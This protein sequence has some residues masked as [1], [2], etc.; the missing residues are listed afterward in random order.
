MRKG[1]SFY[2]VKVHPQGV[3]FCLIL[4]QFQP[5][6]SYESVACTKKACKYFT[7]IKKYEQNHLRYTEKLR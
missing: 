6:V 2:I 3:N 5:A 4:C 1:N 7:N